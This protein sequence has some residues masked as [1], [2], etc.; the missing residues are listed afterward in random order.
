MFRLGRRGLPAYALWT[1]HRDGLAATLHSNVALEPIA[2][3][4][5]MTIVHLQH[6]L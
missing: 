1:V 2:Q 6:E 5:C 3:V 4:L